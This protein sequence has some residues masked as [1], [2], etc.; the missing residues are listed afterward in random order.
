MVQNLGFNL[1]ICGKCHLLSRGKSP[2][3]HIIILGAWDS[4]RI[5]GRG[6]GVGQVSGPRWGR[7]KDRDRDQNGHE[8]LGD[9]T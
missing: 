7:G 8:Y 1:M 9:T 4:I 6:E 3:T 5:G 2:F